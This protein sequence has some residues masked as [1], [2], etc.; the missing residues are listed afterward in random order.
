[1]AMS[2]N[3][4]SSEQPYCFD[5]FSLQQM[6]KSSYYQHM[7][8]H[9][10][11]SGY[12]TFS[13]LSSS[14]I[15][16]QHFSSPTHSLLMQ[17]P[18]DIPIDNERDLTEDSI[19]N[20][21]FSSHEDY[22]NYIK[23]K[24]YIDIFTR[25]SQHNAFHLIDK[26]LTNLPV[27]DIKHC[28][29]V[30]RNWYKIIGKY[31]WK[32]KE[33]KQLANV[34]RNLFSCERKSVYEILSQQTPLKQRRP[35]QQQL[36]QEHIQHHCLFIPTPV[37]MNNTTA[38]SSQNHP[39]RPLTNLPYSSTPAQLTSTALT[40]IITS[41]NND[42][43]VDPSN[44]DNHPFSRLLFSPSSTIVSPRKTYRYEYLK[45]LHGPTVPKR[46][47]I[48]SYI[49]VVDINDQ[50]GICSN[51]TCQNNFCYRCSGPYH[52]LSPCKIKTGPIMSPLKKRQPISPIFSSKTRTNLKRL[53]LR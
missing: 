40:P 41:I 30:S 38:L 42:Q 18:S 25:L 1:M 2:V 3:D 32:Q 17:Q 5:N 6:D 28:L 22:E 11:D 21:R 33:H 9:K 19:Q 49:S 27:N 43:N 10:M 51:P 44:N 4:D 34:K 45:Y 13:S 8:E 7:T 26:I 35:L 29:C 37:S 20:I 14:Y 36:Q 46:C 24:K 47:P 39:L 12:L 16:L 48:C 15:S 23:T 31:Y 53:L 52:P 50:H